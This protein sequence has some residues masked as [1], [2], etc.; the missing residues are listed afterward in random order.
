MKNMSRKIWLIGIVTLF[1]GASIL[2]SISANI[3]E[4]GNITKQL[5]PKPLMA[6]WED[7][8]D[9]YAL[10]SSMHGQGGWKGWDNDPLWTAYVSDD[11]ARSGPHSVDIVADADLVHEYSI[12]SGVWT[13]TA[14]QFIP[15]DFEG[16]SYFILLSDYTDGAGQNNKWAVQLGFDSNT[17]EV[18]SEHGGESLPY[19]TGEWIEI[20][21]EIDL[22]S[23][24]MEI[25]YEDDLLEEK[26]YTS[27]VNN[28]GSGFLKIAA[29][30]LF[31]NLATSVYYDDLS[32][33]GEG[34][35]I[36]DLDCEGDLDWV[37]VEAGATVTGSFTVENIGEA[38]SELNWEI[39][40]NPDWGT[41][42]FTPESGTGLLPGAP[43]TINVEVVAPDEPEM[44]FTGQYRQ[45]WRLLYNRCFS[46]DTSTSEP[47]HAILAMVH[48]QAPDHCRNSRVLKLK[49]PLFFSFF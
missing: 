38:G 1:V 35:P 2:P 41:W 15:D 33:E 3:N 14:W 18:I 21:V 48:E 47:Q 11:E 19:T 16:L 24:W 43:V 46:S 34:D 37:D 49:T 39:D 23:D 26:A 5:Q 30:D 42:T 29:V 40:D 31:A 22:D 44:E 13:Y 36:P 28:D 12:I 32:L 17:G 27:S 10:G 8:F 45:H 7:N 6:F 20:R 9:S 25:Y 4:A